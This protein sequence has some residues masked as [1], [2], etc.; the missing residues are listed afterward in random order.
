MQGLSGNE[1]KLEYITK[2]MEKI[3]D[4]YLLQE[5]HLLERDNTKTLNNGYVMVHHGP[6]N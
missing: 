2:L 4:V 6:Q 3:Y 1:E 5:T